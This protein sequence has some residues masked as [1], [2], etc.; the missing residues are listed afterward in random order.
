MS[1]KTLPSANTVLVIEEDGYCHF[2]LT[3]ILKLAKVQIDTVASSTLAYE[4]AQERDF[5][6][7]IV[8]LVSCNQKDLAPIRF[9]KDINDQVPMKE[10]GRYSTELRS[11]TG[12]EGSYTV[13]FSR[14]DVVP[15]RL[16]EE[17]IARS[18]K[19]SEEE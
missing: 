4:K 15:A 7:I 18:K 1:P 6:T 2:F 5:D 8:N 17:I 14:Y 13:E 16:A 11:M 9:L 19:A 10:I 3:E 12:G